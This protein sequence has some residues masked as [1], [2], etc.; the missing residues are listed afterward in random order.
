MILLQ[1]CL[2]VVIIFGFLLDSYLFSSRYNTIFQAWLAW[3]MSV[4]W[5]G[6]QLLILVNVVAISVRKLRLLALDDYRSLIGLFEQFSLRTQWLILLMRMLLDFKPH[7]A[8]MWIWF[9]EMPSLA[10]VFPTD[11][12]H[13]PGAG[14]K[15]SASKDQIRAGVNLNRLIK[16]ILLGDPIPPAPKP[17]KRAAKR[18]PKRRSNQ[19]ELFECPEDET[20]C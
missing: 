16:S 10:R 14:G 1:K 8:A 7:I 19:L 9:L 6:I 18:R 15:P 3:S 13:P 2:N 12:P 11:Y 5:K 20:S 4:S 17:V